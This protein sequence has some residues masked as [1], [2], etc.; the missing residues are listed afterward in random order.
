MKYHAE[1]TH[2]HGWIGRRTCTC[3]AMFALLAV[4][5]V[6]GVGCDDEVAKEFRAAANDSVETGVN[7][8]LDGIVT[9]IFT[10]ADPEDSTSSTTA[11]TSTGS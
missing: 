7:A 11:T 2:R 8:I 4:L 3:G 1:K 10:V 6:C 5:M 9:G